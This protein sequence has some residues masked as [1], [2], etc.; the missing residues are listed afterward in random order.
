MW[1]LIVCCDSRRNGVKIMKLIST[2][3]G[4]GKKIAFKLQGLS[5]AFFYAFTHYI[6]V[7]IER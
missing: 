6:D 2:I 3:I 1:R 4:K 5:F 7:N